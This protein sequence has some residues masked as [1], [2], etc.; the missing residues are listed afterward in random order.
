MNVRARITLIALIWIGLSLLLGS[1]P[2]ASFSQSGRQKPPTPSPSPNS[3]TRSRQ[4]S[5]SASQQKPAQAAKPDTIQKD[6][7]D[8][9]DVVRV[10]SNLVAVPATVVDSQGIAVTNLKLEDFEL[11]IDGQPNT[12]SEISRADTPVRM[13]MLFD[14]SGSLSESR[15]FEKR[16]AIKFFRNVLRPVDQAA[17]FSVSTDVTLAVPLTNDARR[18]ESTIAG[19]GKPEG[20]TSLRDGIIEAGDYLH[21][22]PGRRVIVI[23]SDGVDTTS[24]ADFDMTMQRALSNDCQIYVV[25]TGLYENANV[26]ALAAERQMQEFSSQTGGAVYLPKSTDDLDYAFAQIAADLAQQ[27]ILSYYPAQD[28][29]DGKYH[30][31]ALRVKTK[32]NARVRARKGFVV[33]SHDRV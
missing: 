27:Y 6:A 11:R 14:N 12:I 18:L 31:I 13:A 28:K 23:V 29:R 25:Q 8:V 33:K 19:F 5:K 15:D 1:S 17:V 20:A 16:A 4:A 7:D 26:R 22:Y 3:N 30:L 24:R 21:P 9:E 2:S 10:T 32:P